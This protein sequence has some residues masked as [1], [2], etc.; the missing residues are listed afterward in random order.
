MTKTH[1]IEQLMERLDG[2]AMEPEQMLATQFRALVRGLAM[3]PEKWEKLMDAH[4]AQHGLRHLMDPDME[5]MERGNFERALLQP[6]MS[7][8]MY[9]QALQFL[10]V[11]HVTIFT[12]L[13]TNDDHAVGTVMNF[14]IKK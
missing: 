11:K 4:M 2:S 8:K 10:D 1:L 9:C 12:N 3:T 6:T 13:T 7:W 14:D 5:K